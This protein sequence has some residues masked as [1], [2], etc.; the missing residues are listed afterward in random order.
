M[1][2]SSA[3]VVTL[4]CDSN[5]IANIR[6]DCLERRFKQMFNTL[7]QIVMQE[8]IESIASSKFELEHIISG[9]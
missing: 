1:Q 4:P 8:H 2:E 3:D 5:F 7:E 6:L 9:T